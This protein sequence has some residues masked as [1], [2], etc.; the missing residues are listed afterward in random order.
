M[1]TSAGNNA[2]DKQLKLFVERIERL[3][4][5]RQGINDDIKDVKAEAKS[6][7]FD[8]RTINEVIRVRKLEPQVRQE[9]KALL[10]TYL[11]AFGIQDD[12]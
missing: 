2:A 1:T 12:E 10:D 7:G 3:I 9:R 5:E 4:E 6:N 8:V 11:A